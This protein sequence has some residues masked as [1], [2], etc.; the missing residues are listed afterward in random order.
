MF[1]SLCGESVK[2]RAHEMREP[3]S[4]VELLEDKRC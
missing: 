1:L 3:H 2:L 4:K